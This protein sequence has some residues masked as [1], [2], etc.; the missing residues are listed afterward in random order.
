MRLLLAVFLTLIAS[1]LQAR[2]Y[3]IL[4][5]GAKNDTT[6]LSTKAIQ[7]AI[8][9]C[10]KEGGGRVVF[11]AGN[12][13]TGTLILKNNV[14]LHLELGATL[15]GSTDLKDYQRIKSSYASLRTHT[16]TVQLICAD[17]VEKDV[18]DG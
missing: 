17:S 18:I 11:P 12:Y 2:D 10:S 8:D 9:L 6:V 16:E 5:F 1:C 7:S 15:Y 14:C 4:D 3:H 13:K